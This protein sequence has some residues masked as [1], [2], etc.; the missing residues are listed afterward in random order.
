[1]RSK[2]QF[3]LILWELMPNLLRSCALLFSIGCNNNVDFESC[4]EI[5]PSVI[6]TDQSSVK[7]FYDSLGRLS[8]VEPTD[9]NNP[10]VFAG[11]SVTQKTSLT[12]DKSGKLILVDFGGGAFLK[13]TYLNGLL[14]SKLQQD[15]T[16]SGYSTNGRGL[17]IT[18]FNVSWND[19]SACSRETFVY[20]TNDNIDTCRIYIMDLN[21]PGCSR[22][23]QTYQ[24][25]FDDRPNPILN[26]LS[27]LT[28]KGDACFLSKNN[29]ISTNRIYALRGNAPLGKEAKNL[30]YD[31]KKRLIFTNTNYGPLSFSY[32]R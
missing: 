4:N 18:R 3:G 26:T 17:P 9:L 10:F 24:N 6:S 20:N 19:R 21:Y 31:A 7:L 23:W 11:I 2:Y 30:I 22:H 16:G 14:V 27:L 28:V 12:Y 8:S 1:M 32:C 5:K 13:Y 29:C 15:Q 25:D